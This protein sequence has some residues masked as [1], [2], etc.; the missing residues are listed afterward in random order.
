MGKGRINRFSGPTAFLSNFFVEKDGKTAEHRFQA[1]KASNSRE[2]EWVLSAPT[3]GEAKQRGR[4][5]QLPSDFE[6]EVLEEMIMAKVLRIKFQD[7]G[8]R[9]KLLATGYLELVHGNHW[10]DV[11]WGVCNGLCQSGPHPPFGKNRLG[12]MLMNVRQTYREEELCS[13]E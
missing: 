6:R 13:Q 5:I 9:A 7:V 2:R 12:Q 3:P 10:H 4:R 1:A 8:L 11:E